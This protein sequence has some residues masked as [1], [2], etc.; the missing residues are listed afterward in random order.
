MHL[1]TISVCC[2][3]C[4]YS[5]PDRAPCT[6]TVITIALGA[7]WPLYQIGAGAL[8]KTSAG[9]VLKIRMSRR[10]GVTEDGGTVHCRDNTCGKGF[11]AESQPQ[12]RE[13]QSCQCSQ[14]EAQRERKEAGWNTKASGPLSMI[15]HWGSYWVIQSNDANFSCKWHVPCFTKMVQF[16]LGKI[17][18]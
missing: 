2:H 3:V 5:V 8:R 14:E 10:L 17:Q 7:A 11:Q 13:E 15:R 9:K 18:P 4:S 1:V 6:E 16:I 12:G